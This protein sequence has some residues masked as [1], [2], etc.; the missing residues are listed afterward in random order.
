VVVLRQLLAIS[1]HRQFWVHRSGPGTLIARMLPVSLTTLDPEWGWRPGRYNS[2]VA[3]AAGLLVV[4]L[5]VLW[6]LI[7]RR[8]P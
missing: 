8:N 5:L 2:L 3:L 1:R 6:A 4:G 7:L